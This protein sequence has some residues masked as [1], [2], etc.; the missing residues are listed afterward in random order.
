[1]CGFAGYL[2]K[3]I[4]NEK[5][6]LINMV[7][8]IQSRGPDSEGF[9]LD[10]NYGF[11]IGH[12]RLSI[13]DL[14]TTG[15]QPILSK[16]HRY[17]LAFNGEIYNHLELRKILDKEQNNYWNG[18]SDTETL[19]TCLELWGVQKTLK[20]ING[21]FAFALWDRKEKNL[22]LARDRIGEKPLYYGYIDGSFVF[23][24]QLK[25]FSDFPHW[26]KV[27]DPNALELYFEYGYVPSPRS[28]FKNIFKLEPAQMVLIRKNDF[29]ISSKIKYWDLKNS[30]NNNKFISD[31]F[32][33][34][35]IKE[36]LGVKLRQSV[37]SRMLSDVPLGAFLSGGIDSSLIVSLM[38]SISSNSLKTFTIG[39]ENKSYDETHKAREISK[40]LG[41]DH[42]E[43]IFEKQDITKLVYSLG[44]VWDEPFSDISQIPTLLVSKVAK[45]QV[46]VV[47]SG[48]G[49]DELFCGYN[50]YL[51]G[52]EL[53][54]LSNNKFIKELYKKIDNN[55]FLLNFLNS[56]NKDRFEKLISAIYSNNLE[57]Y[58]KNIVEVFN[59]NENLVLHEN[60]LKYQLLDIQ[61]SFYFKSDEEKLMYFDLISYLPDDILTKVDRASMSVGLEARA[62]FLNHKLVEYAF[63]LPIKF[64][65][66][67]GSGKKIIK[68]LLGNYLP[69]NLIDK[70]KEG[71]SVPIKE[72]LLG[73][74]NKWSESLIEDEIKSSDSLLNKAKLQEILH[75]NKY[76]KKASQKKWTVL[77][78]LLWKQSFFK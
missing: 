53:Y 59:S 14:S 70:S 57:E 48:D 9:W 8:K 2:S 61:K 27:L 17:V 62:P 71:F 39:F 43:I 64:K 7:N 36:Q 41:T 29:E 12:K 24:S 4:F 51:K 16:N 23:G 40:I 26:K 1:M 3:K 45:G 22:T 33:Y 49:G 78:F 58:Y 42:N 66:E 52:F 19:I 72:L 50:R 63:S 54:K 34:L 25:C 15:H 65:K 28:I 76:M 35:T 67:K 47:L 68:E 56:K 37:E 31:N 11:G 44:E 30:I 5:D 77:M 38:Q 55:K 32:D 46:K 60:S 20:K 21:M 10:S 75:D 73:P 69:N 13:L 74:L 18:T 6:I